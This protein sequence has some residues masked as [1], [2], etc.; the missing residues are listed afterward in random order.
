[1]NITW[2]SPSN[3]A[4]I[5]YWG[6]HG[7]QLPNNP[8]LSLTLSEAF[9]TTT[10]QLQKKRSKKNIE[11]EFYFEGKKNE[12]FAGK[13]ELF[14]GTVQNELPFI[15]D[16][17]LK[18]QS[19]NSFPHSA[20]IASSASAM[21]ALALC[22]LSAHAMQAKEKFS[23]DAFL[24]KASYIAR[25]G[26]GSAARSIYPEFSEWGNA[27]NIRGSS[28]AYAIQYPVK[29]HTDFNELQDSILIVSAEEKTV[30]SRAGHAMM[31]G[32]PMEKQRYQNA[33]KRLR[34]IL[35]ALQKGDWELFCTTVEAEALEL[36]AL[37]MTSSP[38]FILMQPNTL[39]IIN[40]IRTFRQETKI[41]VCFTLDAGP[42]VHMLYP[43]FEKK[44]VRQFIQTELLQFCTKK[45]VIYDMMG[46]GPRQ[47][48]D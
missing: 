34:D 44:N 48:V 12:A 14:L 24:Q 28:D 1:M 30:S 32:H 35:Q 23:Y 29:W 31:I 4:L 22:L 2:Q 20:G 42:N 39:A 8:S 11:L 13:I 26:S 45:K 43:Y 46:S 7:I 3:I 21:S 17:R 9:T 36:H 27:K 6:K 16:Y 10:L 18:I 41:P 15:A 5:K 40:K 33:G 38:S 25:I 37:M 19:E 47:M